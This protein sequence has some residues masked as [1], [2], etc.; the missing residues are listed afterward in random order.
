MEQCCD[1]F[2]QAFGLLSDGEVRSW[3][4]SEQVPKKILGYKSLL[5]YAPYH[6]TVNM[7]PSEGI[8]VP[9]FYVHTNSSVNVLH[10]E[11]Q[12]VDCVHLIHAGSKNAQKIVLT[13][14]KHDTARCIAAIVEEIKHLRSRAGDKDIWGAINC[15][16]PMQHQNIYLSTR[17]LDKNGIS[18]T[19]ARVF[20][21]DLLYVG[22]ETLY[23][24]LNF[25]FSITES[26]DVGS[27]GWNSIAR[28]FIKC[29]CGRGKNTGILCN[30]NVRY[31]VAS[32]AVSTLVCTVPT[33]GYSSFDKGRMKAHMQTHLP[34]DDK[35]RTVICDICSNAYRNKQTLYIHKRQQHGPARPEKVCVCGHQCLSSNFA[36]HKRT[37]PVLLSASSSK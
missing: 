16:V 24:E 10:Y 17:W 6:V 22:P 4:F 12:L 29:T 9:L 37:C 25:G 27:N 5:T 30:T 35:E 21:G 15:N 20:P 33:C 23:Q 7:L 14:S 31:D 13:V 1:V 36:K 28:L 32:R 2:D 3:G 8:N 18:Y 11:D 19:L 26:V 34:S